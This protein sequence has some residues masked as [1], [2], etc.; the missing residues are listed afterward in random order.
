[1]ERK[2]TGGDGRFPPNIRLFIAIRKRS[3]LTTADTFHKKTGFLISL[4]N[5]F[6]LFNLLLKCSAD[7]Q[8]WWTS[9]SFMWCAAKIPS[10]CS[11]ALPVCSAHRE[12]PLAGLVVL[13][14]MWSAAFTFTATC[15]QHNLNLFYSLTDFYS[16]LSSLLF[17]IHSQI[18][19]RIK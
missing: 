11:R 4:W 8:W 18:L 16:T 3:F 10:R 17:K 14:W 6:R 15:C 13:C 19:F 5:Q 2:I 7:F 1:M 9:L 12:M